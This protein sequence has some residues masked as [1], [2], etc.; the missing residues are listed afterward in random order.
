MTFVEFMQQNARAAGWSAVEVLSDTGVVMPFN[1]SEG[2]IKVVIQ[3]C[4]KF[5]GETVLEFS[6]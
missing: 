6:S 2:P 1:S 3:P 4:G 5:E